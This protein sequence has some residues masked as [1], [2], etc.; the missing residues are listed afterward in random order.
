[1]YL[2]LQQAEPHACACNKDCTT[3][4]A[5]GVPG[6]GGRQ[7]CG[8]RELRRTLR[9]TPATSTAVINNCGYERAFRIC[10]SF[11]VQIAS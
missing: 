9:A 3:A 5:A 10:K 4:G 1:M 6:S 2:A 11:G 8:A 7:R